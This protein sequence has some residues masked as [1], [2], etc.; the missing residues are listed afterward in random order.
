MA[1]L[2]LALRRLGA[3]GPGNGA[4]S[5]EDASPVAGGVGKP[6][7]GVADG[8]AGI[9]LVGVVKRVL[10]LG[11]IS[12]AEEESEVY[13]IMGP[14]NEVIAAWYGWN[15]RYDLNGTDRDLFWRYGGME[16][17]RFVDARSGIWRRTV[18]SRRRDE[19][20]GT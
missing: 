2:L 13:A 14:E 3:S 11:A 6:V 4:E 5:D 16:S 7:E 19:R 18:S 15:L 9:D 10:D 20:H 17:S 12:S 8:P 1:G